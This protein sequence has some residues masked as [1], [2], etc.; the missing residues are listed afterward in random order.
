M[1]EKYDNKGRPLYAGETFDGKTGRYRYTYTDATTKKRNSV[2]S[3]TLLPSD[4]VPAGRKQKEGDSLREKKRRILNG[5]YQKKSDAKV[6]AEDSITLYELM[7]AHCKERSLKVRS[8]T[9]KGYIT[10][11]NFMKKNPKLGNRKLSSFETKKDGIKFFDELH[12]KYGRNN[13]T[14]HTLRG[15]LRPAVNDLM[16]EGKIA[17]NPFDFEIKD[18]EYGGVKYRDAMSQR[19]VQR[20]L[21]FLQADSHFRKYLNGVIVLVT[22]GLRISEFCGL[23]INDVNFDK[24]YLEVNR[25]LLRFP[26]ANYKDTYYYIEEPKTK[27]GKRV[28][29]L[30]PDAENALREVIE[31]RPPNVNEQ[32]VWNL[33]KTKSATKFLWIDKDGNYEV[34]QHW[35]NHIRWSVAKFNKIYKEPLPDVS[36]H[37]FRHTYCT[38]MARYL[39]PQEL[40]ALMGHGDSKTTLGVYSH[41]RNE[42]IAGNTY[43]KYKNGTIS[44]YNMN[45]QITYPAM[46][47]DVYEE[48]EPNFNEAIDE[49]DE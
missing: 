37:I 49:D 38:K 13:S 3:Y 7:E 20:Y 43:M 36:P 21:S 47:N 4:R 22:T 18:D 1:A 31:N 27:N 48:P 12:T 17:F 8:S 25:Q 6:K 34:A 41:L 5:D 19:D 10:Q 2:Y 11:L 26:S 40:M 29:P 28:V 32:I 16:L 14:L 42:E 9:Q 33:N 24:H 30:T 15:I 46:S 35:Q 39:L 45:A 44:H 23:T